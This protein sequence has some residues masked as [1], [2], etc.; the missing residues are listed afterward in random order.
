MYIFRNLNPKFSFNFF[1]CFLWNS[2]NIVVFFYYN[3]VYFVTLDSKISPVCYRFSLLF[4]IILLKI[5][6]ESLFSFFTQFWFNFRLIDPQYKPFFLQLIYTSC[7]LVIDKLLNFFLTS[8]W[9]FL[10]IFFCCYLFRSV[11]PIRKVAVL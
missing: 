8:L 6:T 1:F 2:L 3:L 9:H 5:F 4:L 7:Q 11:A 10:N